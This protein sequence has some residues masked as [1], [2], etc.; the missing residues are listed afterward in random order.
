M[1]YECECMDRSTPIRGLREDG[2]PGDAARHF[3]RANSDVFSGDG[4]FRVAV[5]PRG[6]VTRRE[7]FLV[8]RVMAPQ[9][10]Y[11]PVAE[12]EAVV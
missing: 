5:W 7:V 10:V 6:D 2:H 9:Y 1:I 11:E 12:L 3:V 8:T 4:P